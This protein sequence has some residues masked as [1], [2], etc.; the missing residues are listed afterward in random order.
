MLRIGVAVPPGQKQPF[1]MRCPKCSSAIRGQLVTTEDARV[2]AELYEAPFLPEDA[3]TDWQ[4]ITTHPTFPFIPDTERSPFLDITN[5]LG[6]AATPYLRTLAEFNGLAEDWPKLERAYQFYL[7]EDWSRF[8][9]AM[10]RLLEED[11]PEEPSMV[12]RHDAVHRLLDVLIVPL[13]PSS[14]Y[15]DMHQEIWQ[16]AQPS[17]ELITRHS[18]VMSG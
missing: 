10:S 14:Q 13:D 4:V 8:D 2:N 1:S 5:V 18:G 11:W 9:R 3:S 17:Q 6:K 15:L 16:Q 12:R 7:A